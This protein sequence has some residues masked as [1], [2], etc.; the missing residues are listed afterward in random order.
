MAGALPGRGRDHHQQPRGP[1]HQS[2]QEHDEAGEVE[3]LDQLDR[4][5]QDPPVPL[6][7]VDQDP[8][9]GL[10]VYEP[11]GLVHLLGRDRATMDEKELI[12]FQQPG[13][14]RRAI[15]QE[16]LDA[17]LPVLDPP[18]ALVVRGGVDPLVQV[19]RSQGQD[20][21]DDAGEDQ[22]PADGAQGGRQE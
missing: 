4:K 22:S 17:H 12:T 20:H 1:G 19:E 7:G 18:D 21:G 11:L 9:F 14:L 3:R 16:L 2:G 13:S 6:D 8:P 10:G 5:P 15:G